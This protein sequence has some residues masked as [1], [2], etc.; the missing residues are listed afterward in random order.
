M[1]EVCVLIGQVVVVV[2]LGVLVGLGHN[3]YIQDA[4]LAVSG[5]L[6]GV[7]LWERVRSKADTP[8]E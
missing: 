4:L 5:S 7:G 1:R 3:S 8:V 2:V 6:A